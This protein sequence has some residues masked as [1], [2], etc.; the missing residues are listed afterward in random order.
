MPCLLDTGKMNGAIFRLVYEAAL[1]PSCR[2]TPGFT[3]GWSFLTGSRINHVFSHR[4]HIARASLP[5]TDACHAMPQACTH[6]S[7]HHQQK[8]SLVLTR[9]LVYQKIGNKPGYL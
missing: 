8:Y 2:Q 9:A 6:T 7:F 5:G 4:C 3:G 1:R